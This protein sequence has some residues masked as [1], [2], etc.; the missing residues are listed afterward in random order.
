MVDPLPPS[1]PQTVSELIPDD[2]RFTVLEDALN[3]TGLFELLEDGGQHTIFAPTNAAF[4]KIF[5][6][7]GVDG[8]ED[9]ETGFMRSVLLYHII[10]NSVTSATLSSGYVPTMNTNSPDNR[11]V[12]L[13]IEKG[14]TVRL[15][16]NANVTNADIEATNGVIHI[17]DRV[18][19]PPA[20]Y[21]IILVNPVLKV[22]S[23]ALTEAKLDETLKSAGPYTFFAPTDD[24]F[25]LFLSGLRTGIKDISTE[26]LISLLSYH[27]VQ[28]NLLLSELENGEVRTLNSEEVINIISN[29]LGLTI[30]G[31]ANIIAYDIQATN[32]VVHIISKVLSPKEG[33]T[34]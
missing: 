6:D 25:E 13:L 10:D 29:S 1:R 24:A 12:S 30:N 20:V 26:D 22:L 8:V 3:R 9:I 23:E 11:G 31:D 28:D 15:N 18:L 5:P 32:G 34:P 2:D 14:S 21:D 4:N 27:V 33:L 16:G 17:I 7:L 19:I